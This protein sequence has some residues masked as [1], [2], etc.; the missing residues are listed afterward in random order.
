MTIDDLPSQPHNNQIHV[1]RKSQCRFPQLAGGLLSGRYR[2][3]DMDTPSD[4]RFWSVGGKWAKM[5]NDNV[6]SV[7]IIQK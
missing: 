6:L 5:Y 1:C 2:I 7:H 4:G 3:E